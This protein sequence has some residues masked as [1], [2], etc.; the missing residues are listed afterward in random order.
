MRD[1]IEDDVAQHGVIADRHCRDIGS[2]GRR[3]G[4]LVDQTDDRRP[5]Q[6]LVGAGTFDLTCAP[7]IRTSLALRWPTR[8]SSALPAPRSACHRRGRRGQQGRGALR[9]RLHASHRRPLPSSPAAGGKDDGRSRVVALTHSKVECRSG[10]CALARA[11]PEVERAEVG[12]ALLPG[13]GWVPWP[14]WEEAAGGC[15]LDRVRG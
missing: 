14:G 4:E 3:S 6:V 12:G 2:A 9:F 15:R 5:E 13:A 7:S 11:G 1:L 8:S 10:I